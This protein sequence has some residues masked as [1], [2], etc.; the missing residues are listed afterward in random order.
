G[1]RSLPHPQE[2]PRAARVFELPDPL[3][4]DLPRGWLPL[5]PTDPRRLG[6]FRLYAR[7]GRGWHTVAM[8]LAHDEDGSTV[9][10]RMPA[11]RV[12]PAR[13]PATDLVRTEARCLTRMRGRYTPEL[14][15][16]NTDDP[17]E[18]PWLAASYVTRREDDPESGPAP[19]LR[20]VLAE[21]GGPVWGERFLRIARDLCA[22]VALAHRH[23]LVHGALA[24][25]SALVT[26]RG[27]RLV[28]W[29]TATYDEV[30]ST[31]RAE[32][33]RTETYLDAGDDEYGPTK[34]ADVFA[35]GALLLGLAAGRWR[36]PRSDTVQRAVLAD[37]EIEGPFLDLLW[38]CLSP[39]PDERPTAA[40]LAG[41]FGPRLDGTG[42]RERQEEV[43]ASV[44]AKVERHRTLVGQ[45]AGSRRS[46]LAG[47]LNELSVQ[48]GALG[49]RDEALTAVAE[50]VEVYRQLFEERPS[51]HRP[52]DLA[53]CLNNLAVRLGDAGRSEESL[54]AI[55][56]AVDLYRREANRRG[57][58]SY[59]PGLATTLD[60][61]AN[62]L[63]ALGRH[64]EG[65]T[66][67]FEAVTLYRRL[68]A[69]DPAGFDRS[70]ARS[71]NNLANRLGAAGEP[72]E[73]L[74]AAIEAVQLYR[75]QVERDPEEV[76]PELAAA[77]SNIAVRLGVLAVG[78]RPR[79]RSTRP[80]AS[81]RRWHGKCRRP[82][83]RISASH[84]G[85]EPGCGAHGRRKSR[86]PPPARC[87]DPLT[88]EKGRWRPLLTY[89]DRGIRP[90]PLACS[91]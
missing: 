4:A 5:L 31:L 81:G 55:R 35:L 46:D 28:G 43:L 21:A 20:D 86:D 85:S 67:A 17:A 39:A 23:G 71:L 61:L 45:Q 62:R 65:L 6:R 48:L 83:R 26:D 54:A 15:D 16:W 53:R 74:A 82:T 91:S 77:L 25:G 33:P 38:R 37:S 90:T 24:P 32:F 79:R 50:A 36:D 84:S 1:G 34:E 18:P 30:H 44:V 80:S 10:V 13:E 2:A 88:C 47:S 11:P 22:A 60:T 14:L 69:E 29:M 89:R 87:L 66:A 76:R 9:S 12:G 73:A 59:R 72:D 3:P 27:I 64:E 52:S 41:A 42:R 70:L 75:E 49:R 56:E 8:Y 78:K 68:A 7:S 40:E 57:P 63:G 19:N 51:G 58:T